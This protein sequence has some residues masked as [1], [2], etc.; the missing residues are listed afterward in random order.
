MQPKRT[1]SYQQVLDETLKLNAEEVRNTPFS[2]I[3]AEAKRNASVAACGSKLRRAQEE[4][5]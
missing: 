1:K 5:R 4:P 3:L 2:E